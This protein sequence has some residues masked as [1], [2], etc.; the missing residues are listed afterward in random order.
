[1]TLESHKRD[2]ED[3]SAL[4]PYWAILSRPEA[5]H[6]NWDFEEF[7]LT[8][9]REIRGIIEFGEQLSLPLERETALDFG[10]GV[11][12]LTIA[13]SR[14]FEHCYGVDISENMIGQA[15]QLNAAIPNCEFIVNQANNL[16]IFSDN[17]FDLVYT[18]IVLQHIPD[19]STIRAYISEFV[20]TLK[21]GGLLV[22]Q[23][24]CQIPLKNR[25][26]PR[27]R[28]YR[29][30][31]F[32]GLDRRLLYEKLGLHPMRMN[33]VSENEVLSLLNSL[34]TRV[35]EVRP[36]SPAGSS[37]VSNTYFVTR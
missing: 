18:N 27:R 6:G 20:R 26:Q 30:L 4:D 24:P 35:L 9:E 12:R 31:K 11:G 34:R 8:G 29:F 25:L 19:K 14:Y 36:A 13:L 21:E 37:F 3:L 23:L 33:F 2:W 10:C 5:Q 1:M 15:R 32:L 16:S 28:A 17:Y 22:F 7:F